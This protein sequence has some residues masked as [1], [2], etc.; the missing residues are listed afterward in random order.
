MGVRTVYHGCAEARV[1]G[2]VRV[3]P[4]L[5]AALL[6]D[7]VIQHGITFGQPPRTR[8]GA[9]VIAGRRVTT[10]VG[11]RSPHNITVHRVVLYGIARCSNELTVVTG[12]TKV[13]GCT[14]TLVK[15]FV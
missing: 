6:T 4:W 5:V 12:G 14:R 3:A 13:I 15:Y 10:L 9:G 2:G 7:V 1:W 8:Q 11:V